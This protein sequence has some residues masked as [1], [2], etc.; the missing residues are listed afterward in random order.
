MIF[1]VVDSLKASTE[2][3]SDTIYDKRDEAMS[4]RARGK[5]LYK[6]SLCLILFFFFAS[7]CS[8]IFREFPIDPGAHPSVALMFYHCPLRI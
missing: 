4:R 7:A 1:F 2:G 6:Y 8:K 3:E 5:R